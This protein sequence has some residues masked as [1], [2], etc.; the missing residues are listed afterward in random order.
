VAAARLHMLAPVLHVDTSL[1]VDVAF[2]ATSEQYCPPSRNATALVNTGTVTA[3]VMVRA[4]HPTVQFMSCNS[5]TSMLKR[6]V[7]VS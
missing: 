1:F 2:G 3:Y 6:T 7:F 4:L 5:T